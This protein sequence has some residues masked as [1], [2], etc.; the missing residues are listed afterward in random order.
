MHH[1]VVRLDQ[2]EAEQGGEVGLLEGG[3]AAG[4]G[5]EQD[6]PRGLGGRGRGVLQG[7]GHGLEEAAQPGQR[8]DPVAVEFCQVLLG[9]RAHVDV[10]VGSGT[11]ATAPAPGDMHAL[12]VL[13]INWELPLQ[14]SAEVAQH[15]IVTK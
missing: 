13:A 6:D 14:A 3:L 12:Q 4:A 8:G 1:Q 5:A 11:A 2:G 15:C 9:Q 10:Q 7:T